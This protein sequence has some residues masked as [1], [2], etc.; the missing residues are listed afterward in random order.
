ML[1]KFYQH[2]I[3]L[4][5]D[6]S[7]EIIEK[8]RFTLFA[9]ICAIC[10]G[11]ISI[12][13]HSILAT[14]L[15]LIIGDLIGLVCYIMALV[16]LSPKRFMLSVN[17][18]VGGAITAV[19]IHSLIGDY[20]FPENLSAFK[21]YHTLMI[22]LLMLIFLGVVAISRRQVILF[23]IISLI[24]IILHFVVLILQDVPTNDEFIATLITITVEASLAG[25]GINF[26]FNFNHRVSTNL[27]KQ[28]KIITQQN[29]VISK[30]NS[31]L[32]QKINDRTE[33]LKQSND[34]LKMFSY[35][36]SHDVREPLRMISSFIGL[37]KRELQREKLDR[38]TIDEYA[39]FA[40]D[41]SQ[42]LD[43]MINNLL[44]YTR[45]DKNKNSNL[46]SVDLNDMVDIVQLNLQVLI[47][48]KKATIYFENL[49]KIY[50]NEGNI[51]LL[52]QNL[53]ANAIKYSR[54]EVSPIIHISAKQVLDNIVIEVKDNGRGI[55]KNIID[56]I[57]LPF[58]RG[59]NSDEEK[60]TGI[61]LAICK[62]IVEGVQGKISVHSSLGNGSIFRLEFPT[63]TEKINK[64]I[65][66]E[67][68]IEIY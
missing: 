24:T 22:Q 37:I 51:I 52:F 42:R 32:E 5:S 33:A 14:R 44:I 16:L 1:L 45:L 11:I 54:S 17:L 39:Y 8:S 4:F 40:V 41:G 62:K 48:E 53:I 25:L 65:V 58:K 13:V 61:G 47:R 34:N 20:I 49:P 60:G 36:V 19:S 21:V 67:S 63:F 56:H 29:E 50:A 28:K 10:V 35:A 2:K 9:C 31:Y 46:E 15:H 64:K 3:S 6:K 12:V 27:K 7:T 57:F 18:L 43:A 66:S 30:E 23:S 26:F 68:L 55:D 59:H 38:E